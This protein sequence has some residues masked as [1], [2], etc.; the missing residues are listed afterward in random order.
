MIK[1]YLIP[2]DKRIDIKVFDLTTIR[3]DNLLDYY[4]INDII[5]PFLLPIEKS[6]Y[7]EHA[8][9]RQNELYTSSFEIKEKGASGVKLLI[10]YNKILIKNLII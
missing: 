8:G 1:D 7:V 4:I 10:Y 2:K 3:Y 6:G 5:K 9:G